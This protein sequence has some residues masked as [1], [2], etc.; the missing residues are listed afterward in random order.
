MSSSLTR[1]LR[2]VLFSTGMSRS[3]PISWSS[4]ARVSSIV[5]L[6]AFRAIQHCISLLRLEMIR[7]FQY[8]KR[9]KHNLNSQDVL[10][11][12]VVKTFLTS[13]SL[14]YHSLNSPNRT[15]SACRICLWA[16][17]QSHWFGGTLLHASNSSRC[18]FLRA[19]C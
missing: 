16:C 12:L 10:I 9:L 2:F 8:S 11:N 6:A 18:Q 14:R 4:S 7:P 13:P 1:R 19:D 15:A 3:R 5:A 17:R